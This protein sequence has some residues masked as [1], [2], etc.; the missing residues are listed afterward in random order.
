M[1]KYIAIFNE[2]QYLS[3]HIL[4][5]GYSET[6]CIEIKEQVGGTKFFVHD[7]NQFYKEDGTLV[8]MSAPWPSWIWDEETRTYIPP[9]PRPDDDHTW[10]EELKNWEID[11][12]K[13]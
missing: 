13:L 11:T 2:D 7:S 10:N 3:T 9:V 5:E 1:V 12:N 6:R 8:T 4:E